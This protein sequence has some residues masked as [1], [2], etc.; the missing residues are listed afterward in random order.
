MQP[1]CGRCCLKTDVHFA[2]CYWSSTGC[3]EVHVNTTNTAWASVLLC[4]LRVCRRG[5]LRR[6]FP[7]YQLYWCR[8]VFSNKPWLTEK[9][10]C[11]STVIVLDADSCCVLCVHVLLYSICHPVHS[12]Q[13]WILEHSQYGAIAPRS[14]R[15][16]KCEFF[17]RGRG[18]QGRCSGANYVVDKLLRLMFN[19]CTKIVFRHSLL[20]GVAWRRS[21][22]RSS[23][24]GFDSCC[25]CQVTA[26]GNFLT[27]MCLC[28]QAV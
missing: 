13:W 24:H 1:S 7:M 4:N 18:V 25:R 16:C 2:V 8:G 28:H 11:H 15:F 3:A 26:L 23:G 22:L 20:L 6:N 27:S 14:S 17:W 5:R 19:V 12:L 10:V 9:F 21:G